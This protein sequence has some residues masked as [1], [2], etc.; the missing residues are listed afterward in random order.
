MDLFNVIAFILGTGFFVCVL[1]I[2]MSFFR[3]KLSLWTLFCMAAVGICISVGIDNLVNLFVWIELGITFINFGATVFV[4]GML[5]MMS[6]IL[7]NFIASRG[8]TLVR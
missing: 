8:K 4:I 7:M 3:T 2:L 1:F 5:C 6:V